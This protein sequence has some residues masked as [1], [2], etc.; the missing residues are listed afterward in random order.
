MRIAIVP[1]M[2][3][4]P[5]VGKFYRDLDLA[6]RAWLR[7]PDD[8][9]L[10]EALG[11]HAGRLGVFSSEAGI[12]KLEERVRELLEVFHTLEAQGRKPNEAQ[13][14]RIRAGMADV[15]NLLQSSPTV[16]L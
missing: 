3:N 2:K 14:R 13:M 4:L 5:L 10:L 1:D 9:T 12:E 16:A 7:R 15:L 6:W 11:A 8:L